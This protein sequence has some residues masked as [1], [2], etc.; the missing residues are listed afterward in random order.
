MNG[1]TYICDPDL[2]HEMPGHK[3]FL[4]TYSSAP[5]TYGRW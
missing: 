3:W 4:T 5:T 1:K 2:S